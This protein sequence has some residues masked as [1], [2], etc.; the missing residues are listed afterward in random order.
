MID[1]QLKR[2]VPNLGTCLTGFH[3]LQDGDML[4]FDMIKK[5]VRI[6][7]HPALMITVGTW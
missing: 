5:L 7:E 6:Q 3:G 1:L 2:G 4:P